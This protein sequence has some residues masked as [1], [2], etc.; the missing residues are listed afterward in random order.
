MA[1]ARGMP[2]DANPYSRAAQPGH[3]TVSLIRHVTAEERLAMR[4]ETAWRIGWEAVDRELSNGPAPTPDARRRV[5]RPEDGS[6]S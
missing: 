1:R 2:R 3:G 6:G 4:L 5:P